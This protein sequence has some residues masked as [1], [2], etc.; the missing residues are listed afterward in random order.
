MRVLMR[1][2]VR[3]ERA[4]VV[5]PARLPE[6]LV[7]AE[8]GQVHARVAGAGD[9]GALGTRPVLVVPGGHEDLVV[10]DQPAVAVGVD[11]GL[12]AD[13]VAVALHPADH[14]D[15]G[16]EDPVLAA[17]DAARDEGP[18]VA[19]LGGARGVAAR[20]RAALVEAVAAVVV[21]GL[22]GRVRRLVVDVRARAVVAHHED[23]VA[24]AAVAA[25]EVGEVD[26]RDGIGRD[27]PRRGHRPASAVDETGGR[28]GRALAL[29]PGREP[30]QR[31]HP[32]CPVAAV[33]AEPVDVHPVA[34]VGGDLELDGLAL[35]V[36]DVGGEALQVLIARAGDVPDARRRALL[37]VLGRDRVVVG[38]E[39]DPRV[40]RGRRDRRVAAEDQAELRPAGR[41]AAGST[42]L[43]AVDGG[44]GGLRAA[45][46]AAE[47]DRRVGVAAAAREAV[48]DVA[49]GLVVEAA[50]GDAQVAAEAVH[51]DGAR[52]R[53]VGEELEGV[54]GVRGRRDG[55]ARAV[56]EDD[57]RRVGGAGSRRRA[58]AADVPRG[59]ALRRAVEAR[60]PRVEQARGALARHVRIRPGQRRCAHRVGERGQRAAP[61]RAQVGEEA[62]RVVGPLVERRRRLVD[63]RGVRLAVGGGAVLGE[64]A[65]GVGRAALAEPRTRG[66]EGLEGVGAPGEL[67]LQAVEDLSGDHGLGR[68]TS[69]DA[70]D[71]ARRGLG[72]AVAAARVDAERGGAA[73]RRRIVADDG[74][75]QRELHPGLLADEGDGLVADGVELRAGGAALHGQRERLAQGLVDRVAAAGRQARVVGQHP[76]RGQ[77]AVGDRAA[78][79]PRHAHAGQR[80]DR[81][82]EGLLRR[83]GAGARAAGAGEQP[84][85]RALAD[86]AAHAGAHDVLKAREQAVALGG[87]D[88]HELADDRAVSPHDPLGLAQRARLEAEG[89]GV[90][91]VRGG[92]A[93]AAQGALEGT[94]VG[95][96]ACDQGAADD[97]E[98]GLARRAQHARRGACARRRV[99]A[100]EPGPGRRGGRPQRQ[101]GHVARAEHRRRRCDW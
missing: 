65:A 13:V 3:D 98:L 7:A 89:A 33:P 95:G 57:R 4:V 99:P 47:G 48:G 94:R 88:G 43:A 22:P 67:D 61:G 101:A 82:R 77:R 31:R 58:R 19:D 84:V 32:A 68:A 28:L 16:V 56:A 45:G 85:P 18:V 38:P 17:L 34:D 26:A 73:A 42:G 23:D 91:A 50:R 92:L 60:R 55:H 15:L 6:D 51:A 40:G 27:R 79:A 69:A 9:V 100:D 41:G 78:G 30:G 14:R 62:D 37:G 29:H 39:R 81:E 87:A 64:E 49:L 35:V 24:L 76:A 71:A 20:E 12:V 93:D 70:H 86:G 8:E 36:A 90:D 53:V 63:V 5:L 96:V 54:R 74:D 97:E 2:L 21:V 11:A 1:L 25:D 44:D 46:G 59:A 52:R 10:A 80:R 72:G 75:R 66:V 83:R